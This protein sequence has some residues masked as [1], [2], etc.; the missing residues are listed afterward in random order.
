MNRLVQLT[1]DFDEADIAWLL[2][3]DRLQQQVYIYSDEDKAAYYPDD[4]EWPIVW[5]LARYNKKHIFC[6]RKL[7]VLFQINEVICRFWT[8]YNGD[9]FTQIVKILNQLLESK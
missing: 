1:A 8:K 5:A 6:S 9:G 7:P 3:F 2:C 4:L